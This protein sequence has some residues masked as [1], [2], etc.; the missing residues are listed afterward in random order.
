[1]SQSVKK[2]KEADDCKQTGFDLHNF[3]VAQS[4]QWLGYG[5]DDPVRISTE[6]RFSAPKT[7]RPAVR[8]SQP[9]IQRYS[10]TKTMRPEREAEH[11]PT[12]TVEITAQNVLM[13][14][15]GTTSPFYTSH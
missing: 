6:A 10:L 14:S 12:Y 3:T 7:S 13:V 4:T 8:R 2:K 11:S 5:L 15:T 9:S 1:M